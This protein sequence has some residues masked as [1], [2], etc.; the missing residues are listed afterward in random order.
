MKKLKDEHVRL[1]TITAGYLSSLYGWIHL[2]MQPTIALENVI[3]MN[4]DFF[5]YA[6]LLFVYEC[7]LVQ[8]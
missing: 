2:S 1:V 4:L 6:L 5:F 3:H 7:M 8:I